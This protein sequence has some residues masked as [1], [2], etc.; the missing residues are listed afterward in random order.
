MTATPKSAATSGGMA[1]L[2]GLPLIPSLAAARRRWRFMG[3]IFCK[4]LSGSQPT[5]EILP[6]LTA[7]FGTVLTNGRKLYFSPSQIG[8]AVEGKG[9]GSNIQGKMP[10]TGTARVG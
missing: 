2:S 1:A 3:E 7:G 9:K 4:S 10:M 6:T 5:S 8:D